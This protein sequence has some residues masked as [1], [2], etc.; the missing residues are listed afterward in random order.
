[1][2]EWRPFSC[3]FVSNTHNFAVKNLPSSSQSDSFAVNTLVSV[4]ERGLPT[5]PT[6]FLLNRLATD[7]RFDFD[8]LNLHKLFLLSPEDLEW[9]ELILGDER[10]GN[11]PARVFQAEVIPEFIPDYGFVKNL[12]LPECPL[13]WIL[14]DLESIDNLSGAERVDFFLPEA[15]LVIEIDGLQHSAPVQKQ[16]DNVRDALLTHSGVEVAGFYIS[17][18]KRW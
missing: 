2:K 15:K 8:D 5:R 16:R 14:G 10:S 17:N 6:A 9:G 13:A 11:F 1:M 3:G 12:M 4:L 18:K 7:H